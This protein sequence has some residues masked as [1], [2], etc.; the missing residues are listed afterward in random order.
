[1]STAAATSRSALASFS[2]SAALTAAP[3]QFFVVAGRGQISSS[4][5]TWGVSGE[6]LKI[7]VGVP[8]NYRRH[9][10]RLVSLGDT[11]SDPQGI[12]TPCSSSGIYSVLIQGATGLS[13]TG[14]AGNTQSTFA[15][16]IVGPLMA[17]T[18]WG[19][20][21]AIGRI[22]TGKVGTIAA[23]TVTPVGT[24]SAQS[25]SYYLV[26]HDA[27]GGTT[28]ISAAGTTSAS[29]TTANLNGTNYNT[30]T[31]PF[32]PGCV[33]FDVYRDATSGASLLARNVNQS[34]VVGGA[35]AYQVLD[36]GQAVSTST[37]PTVDTTGDLAIAGAFVPASAAFASL[38]TTCTAGALYYCPDCKSVADGAA[39][40]SVCAGGGTGSWARCD[41]SN[42]LHCGL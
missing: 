22:T 7:N 18:V 1:L 21:N 20:T 30:I 28:A 39:G 31:W 38:P 2:S 32:Y 13:D 9:S 33:S 10:G 6:T 17:P 26:C 3:D 5:T 15:Q 14:D 12:F 41:A 23:P 4:N 29:V 27:N 25:H 40:G 42:G 37:A 34:M 36:Q 19:G 11:F 24:N 16:K 35:S 8:V